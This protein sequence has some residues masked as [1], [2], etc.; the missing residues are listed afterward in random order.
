MCIRD[1]DRQ[2]NRCRSF[3]CRSLSLGL[4][5]SLKS[6]KSPVSRNVES[7]TRLWS[8]VDSLSR[9]NIKECRLIKYDRQS[10]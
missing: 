1:R 5:F 2:L 6:L 7:R 4:K 10:L 8:K 9:I 3:F